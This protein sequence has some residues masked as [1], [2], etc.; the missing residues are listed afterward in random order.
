MYDILIAERWYCKMKLRKKIS[1][2]LE[3]ENE[4]YLDLLKQKNGIQTGK[5]INELLSVFAKKEE[6]SS[7]QSAKDDLLL[8]CKFQ[9]KCLYKK[10]DNCEP[11]EE[12]DIYNNI[13]DYSIIAKYLNDGN[14]LTQH[15]LLELKSMK[16]IELFDGYILVPTDFIFLNVDDA[17][18]CRN[19]IIIEC[20]NSKK[21]NIPVFMF[22]TNF[23]SIDELGEND[24]QFIYEKCIQKYKNFSWILAN[25]VTPIHDPDKPM[26]LLNKDEWDSAPNIGYFFVLA[27]NDSLLQNP[28]LKNPYGIQLFRTNKAT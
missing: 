24:Y 18:N 2:D 28:Y 27:K 12:R 6:A 4:E 7:L 15:D 8:Y 10:L 16:K 19:A 22:F 21:Y 17:K 14:D 9:L 3:F 13:M 23:S 1:I 5:C 20:K 11:Y 26:F 25:Q